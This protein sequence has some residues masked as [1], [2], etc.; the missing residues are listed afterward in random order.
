M[1]L[2]LMSRSPLTRF[3]FLSKGIHNKEYAPLPGASRNSPTRYW[4]KVI[5]KD[6]EEAV[7]ITKGVDQYNKKMFS[8]TSFDLK[9]NT[10]W[11]WAQA[12]T[13]AAVITQ[14]PGKP[15]YRKI[16]SASTDPT[17]ESSLKERELVFCITYPDFEVEFPNFNKTNN[18]DRV[19][20]KN[21]FVRIT[22]VLN[23]WP[24]S[25]NLNVALYN[26]KLLNETRDIR[27]AY[28][29]FREIL[30]SLLRTK[31]TKR[32]FNENFPSNR[33]EFFEKNGLPADLVI[34][35]ERYITTRNKF[36]HLNNTRYIDEVKSEFNKI[37]K[38]EL[39]QDLH[40]FI[41]ILQ[42]WPGPQSSG[43]R[44]AE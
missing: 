1:N 40:T 23:Q 18:K 34:L 29:S 33:K 38:L 14:T 7:L 19:K 35:L 26:L 5:H 13:F 24:A 12:K 20:I 4:G 11:V 31:I 25:E 6:P 27:S 42:E 36:A 39:I 16:T 32:D 37:S 41:T 21:L 8:V 3:P 22:F 9:N 10:Y 43:E 30:E 15:I 44:A 17:H 28:M 2:D